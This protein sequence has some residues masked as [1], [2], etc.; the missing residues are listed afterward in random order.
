SPFPDQ[1]S[2]SDSILYR[3]HM[4]LQGKLPRSLKGYEYTLAV[5]DDHS[6]YGWKEYMKTKDETPTLIKELITRLE[7]LTGCTVK[8]VR[9]DGGGE[10]NNA[11]L[12]AWFK[13]KGITHEKSAPDT[14]QQDG[15]SERFNG[16]TH[17][18]AL[19]M[20]HEAGLSDG[21]WPEAHEYACHVRNCSPSRAIPNSTPHE[22]FFGTKPDVS[23][24]RV[25]GSR[26]HV[27]V[28]PS[29]RKKTS[30]HSV[31]GI[32]CGFAR[33]YKAYYIWIPSLHRFSVSRDVIVYENLFGIKSVTT[34]TPSS[35]PH[36]PLDP[37]LPSFIPTP[38]SDP[39]PPRHTSSESTDDAPDGLL[40]AEVT[41]PTRG[42]LQEED[43]TQG[44]K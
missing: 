41:H 15:V 27:R 21:F 2:R 39:D 36:D 33:G 25:F 4:D 14:Q 23:S 26:C 34:S 16:T 7:N 40:N 44:R 20:L 42:V 3:L 37:S 9:T 19:S 12:E 5:I 30:A 28:D 32:F 29:N 31:E 8:C 13:S 1:A 10:F 18:S 11:E 17:R 35:L 6:R 22:M 24:L 43:T 38:S